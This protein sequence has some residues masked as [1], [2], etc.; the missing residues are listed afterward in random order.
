MGKPLVTGNS[1]GVKCLRESMQPQSRQ[2][3]ARPKTINVACTTG[4]GYGMERKVDVRM[5]GKLQNRG[6]ECC[7]W[8]HSPVMEAS[9]RT[10]AGWLLPRLRTSTCQGARGKNGNHRA[11]PLRQDPGFEAQ[12]ECHRSMGLWIFRITLR[13]NHH[14][15]VVIFPQIPCQCNSTPY[16]CTWSILPQCPCTIPVVRNFT[17]RRSC[18]L[19]PWPPSMSPHFSS[20][21]QCGILHR[22]STSTISVVFDQIR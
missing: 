13:Y 4:V 22:Q 2:Y 3:D 1:R 7:F 17:G 21:S 11:K 12:L 16:A 18:R 14:P 9:Q 19:L 20:P 6:V 10:R 5:G 15:S 8:G